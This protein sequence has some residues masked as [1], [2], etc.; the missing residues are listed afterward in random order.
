MNSALPV[1][2]PVVPGTTTDSMRR[3]LFLLFQF[4]KSV[5]QVFVLIVQFRILLF[6]FNYLLIKNNYLLFERRH[7]LFQKSNMISEDG[8]GAVL[9]DPF[10][11]WREWVHVFDLS[12]TNTEQSQQTPD[13][14]NE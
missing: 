3:C 1:S 10:F 2:N 6:K 7:L 5:F 12:L 11:N 9:R 13:N 14:H 8:C 4:F